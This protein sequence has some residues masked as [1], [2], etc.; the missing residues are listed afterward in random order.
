[1]QIA[2]QHKLSDT[3]YGLF[4]EPEKLRAKFTMDNIQWLNDV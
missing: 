3:P 1:M 2:G 4:P